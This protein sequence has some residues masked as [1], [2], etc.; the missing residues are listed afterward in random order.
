MRLS[1]ACSTLL[2]A[3]LWTGAVGGVVAGDLTDFNAA[4]ETASSHNR[5]AIGYLRTGNA[6]G[7]ALELDRLRDAWRKLTA[8]F[9][10]HPPDAFDGNPL[11][12][13]LFTAI[14]A[15]LVG[16]DM[17]LSSGRPKIA[18]Q[19]LIAI[20]EDLHKL[21]QASGVTV[22]ADCI[23]DSNKAAAALLAYDKRDIDWSKPETRYAITGKA[24][25]YGHE[26]ARCDAM[27]SEAVR[28]SPQFRRL[29]DGAQKSLARIPK[30]LATRN[31]A[32]LR[33]VL[34]ELREIDGLLSVRYG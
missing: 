7:A 10:G 2:A 24:A 15:R 17:M 6:D 30:A 14:D 32:L 25:I 9:A 22:L 23:G 5:A 31:A 12:P 13:K 29:I 16:A 18:R 27:A 19:S 3:A 11:Y 33:R 8:R 21:R 4:I 34:T 28:R 26:L 1:L 20:R